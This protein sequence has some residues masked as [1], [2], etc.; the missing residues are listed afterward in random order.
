MT[1]TRETWLN[2]AVAGLSSHFHATTGQYAP[3]NIRVS[4][5]WPSTKALSRKQ[6]R[7][8]ECWDEVASKDKQFE[9]FISPLLDDAIEVLSTLAHEMVHATVGH[10]AKHGAAFS[11]FG[12]KI[13][14]EGKP[15]YMG[16]GAH[17]RETVLKPLAEIHGAYPHG[18]LDKA[19]G[20]VKKQST[21]MLK[22]ECSDCGY[23]A[24]VSDKWLTESG[25]PICPCN[26]QPMSSI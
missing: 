18:T 20:P 11:Q 4:C 19:A 26:R 24:R 23:I 3:G 1:M 25:A 16:A 10:K 9:I 5:G 8:G 6:R 22:V 21:R 12:R 13:G 7:L 14:L 17:M 15:T 2:E